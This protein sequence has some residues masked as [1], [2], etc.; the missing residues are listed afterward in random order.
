MANPQGV[1]L[2]VL[3][4]LFYSSSNLIGQEYHFVKSEEEYILL[5]L[6]ENQ[7]F[8]LISFDSILGK[9]QSVGS[10]KI[11]RDSLFLTH[12]P[13]RSRGTVHIEEKKNSCNEIDSLL[14]VDFKIKSLEGDYF[15]PVRIKLFKKE[16][17]LVSI[18]NNE[19]GE[20]SLILHPDE[21]DLI[22]LSA[23][24]FKNTIIPINHLFKCS[25]VDVSLEI[26]LNEYPQTI[27]NQK[28]FI[29]K[30]AFLNGDRSELKLGDFRFEIK[31]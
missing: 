24:G 26:D 9:S 1:F 3:L 30:G 15:F 18:L 11:V 14:R 21:F 25:K 28:N 5:D 23:L 29:E 6:N 22:I 12:E 10:Y 20:A 27:Y 13:I 8:K 16:E 19:E 31:K 17:Y 2:A 4:C 7:R